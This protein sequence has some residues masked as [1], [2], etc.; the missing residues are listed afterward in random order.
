MV[1]DEVRK[2]SMARMETDY[3]E[4][5]ME[6]KMGPESLGALGIMGDTAF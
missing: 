1:Y 3:S 6:D 5:T 2:Q 4:H